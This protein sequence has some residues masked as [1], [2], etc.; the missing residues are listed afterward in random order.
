MRKGKVGVAVGAGVAGLK[1]VGVGRGVE[2][3]VGEGGRGDGVLPGT[4]VMVTGVVG[5]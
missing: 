3:E 5:G 2:V 4:D 1:E